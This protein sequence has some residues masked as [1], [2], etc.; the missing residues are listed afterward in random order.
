MVT[1]SRAILLLLW[2]C[3]YG[4]VP[5]EPVEKSNSKGARYL[6][7]GVIDPTKESWVVA[8]D[9]T[10]LTESLDGPTE[11]SVASVDW[12]AVVGETGDTLF[13]IQDSI[14]RYV[15][16]PNQIA[17]GGYYALAMSID[18]RIV[19]T[20]PALIPP[21]PIVTVGE[22]RLGFNA[23]NKSSVLLDASVSEP[24]PGYAIQFDGFPVG[25]AAV[26][27]CNT[28]H[29]GEFISANCTN[30]FSEVRFEIG[31]RVGLINSDTLSSFVSYVAD[32]FANYISIVKANEFNWGSE[33]EL[34]YTDPI[35]NPSNIKGASG[36]I[37][38]Q[39]SA[40][41]TVLRPQ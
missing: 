34:I 12:A 13:M 5:E 23:R 35:V 7:E 41:I 31:W 36:Y 30:Q 1:A 28:N 21:P 39:N 6:V 9:I 32:D 8:F 38:F 22:P 25:E 37:S 4:C 15:L 11:P 2:C 40:E 16:P 33:G 27:S 17:S 18:G 20:A 29:D 24:L 26:S 14:D 10:P 19:T 3:T